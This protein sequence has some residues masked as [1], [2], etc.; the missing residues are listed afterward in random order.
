MYDFVAKKS[1][2]LAM[3]DDSLRRFMRLAVASEVILPW[4]AMTGLHPT[5]SATQGKLSTGSPAH[6]FSSRKPRIL[7][8]PT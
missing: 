7:V 6:S 1:R 5:V 8:D 4:Y 2:L 3:N